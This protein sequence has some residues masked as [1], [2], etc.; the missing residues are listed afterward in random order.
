[1]ADAAAERDEREDRSKVSDLRG[2]ECSNERAEAQIGAQRILEE[3]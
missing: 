3:V 2:R 1:M